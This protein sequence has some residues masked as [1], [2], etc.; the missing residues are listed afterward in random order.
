MNCK[1]PT[2]VSSPSDVAS[3]ILEVRDYATWYRQYAVASKVKVDYRTTQ[4]ELTPTAS[5]VIRDWAKDEPLSPQ[6]LDQLIEEL[7]TIAAEAPV[8]TL[9]LAAPAPAEIKKALVGWCRTNLNASMLVTFRFNSTLLGGMVV[10]YGSRIY[11]WSFRR[12]IMEHRHRL[13]EIISNV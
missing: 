11:D 13:P 4:P 1:L 7:E 2:S 5:A 10:R 8:I 3:L 12:S 9:T 6:R